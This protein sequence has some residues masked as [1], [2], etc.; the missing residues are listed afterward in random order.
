L[1]FTIRWFILFVKDPDAYTEGFPA[2]HV[3]KSMA[4]EC[5]ACSKEIIRFP[6]PSLL[7]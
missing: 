7:L 5:K 1:L 3:T 6:K 4:R 2:Q